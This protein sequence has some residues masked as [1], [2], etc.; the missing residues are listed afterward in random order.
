[1]R[2]RHI[3]GAGR[4]VE[5]VSAGGV[6]RPGGATAPRILANTPRRP[7]AAF[8]VT[9]VAGEPPNDSRR[10]AIQPRE[11]RA[12]RRIERPTAPLAP[13][14][15]RFPGP[16]TGLT[17]SRVTIYHVNVLVPLGICRFEALLRECAGSAPEGLFVPVNMAHEPAVKR[18]VGFFDGQ[19]LYRHAKDAFGHH[20]PNCHPVKL[21][22][23]VCADRGWENRGVRFYT[24]IPAARHD[25]M[26]HGYWTNRLLAMR[27]EGVHVESR[28]LRYRAR[29]LKQADG[30]VVTDYVA[31]EI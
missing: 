20:H 30:S 4:T 9:P 22:D 27:R 13:V 7:A 3:T 8:A 1:M 16:Y 26:R 11:Q 17:R 31:R 14:A 25:E 28:P 29:T 10:F 18:A 12:R 6:A 19:N 2:M 21:F 5:T 15:P 24:G 23:A